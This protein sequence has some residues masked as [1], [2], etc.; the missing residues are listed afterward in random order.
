[1]DFVQAPGAGPQDVSSYQLKFWSLSFELILRCRAQSVS[2]WLPRRSD[3]AG[4]PLNPSPLLPPVT[5]SPAATP[6]AVCHRLC[7]PRCCSFHHPPRH[8]NCLFSPR[9]RPLHRKSGR[10][11]LFPL[12]EMRCLPTCPV[13][14]EQP[15]PNGGGSCSSLSMVGLSLSMAG[16]TL[17]TSLDYANQPY[18]RLPE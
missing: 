15:Q 3:S 14:A 17:D 2:L 1:M 10:K 5:R 13:E 4:Y 8:Q 18:Y 11:S 9:H 16:L 6:A 12:D 7:R